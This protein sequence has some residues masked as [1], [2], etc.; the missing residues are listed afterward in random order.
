MHYSPQSG[1][2]PRQG[3]GSLAAAAFSEQSRVPCIPTHAW[4]GG[5]HRAHHFQ[6]ADNILVLGTMPES[7]P[8]A[9][10][11]H[12]QA[13]RRAAYPREVQRTNTGSMTQPCRCAATGSAAAPACN[14]AA[15]AAAAAAGH[16]R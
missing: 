14:A 7:D 1:C 6:P 15:A 16:Q 12:V 10:H 4:V 9:A 8:A 11:L 5:A 2:C 3:K 13:P